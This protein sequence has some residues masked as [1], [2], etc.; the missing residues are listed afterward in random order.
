MPISEERSRCCRIYNNESALSTE[1]GASV[2]LSCN[3]T[4]FES[5]D[6]NNPQLILKFLWF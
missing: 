3:K 4:Y 2:S 5:E 1:S 6:E